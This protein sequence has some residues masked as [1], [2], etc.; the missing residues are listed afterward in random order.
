VAY[1]RQ[2]ILD[3]QYESRLDKAFRA[4]TPAPRPSNDP[5]RRA[6]LPLVNGEIPAWFVASTERQINRVADITKEMGLKAPVIVGAQ[7]GWRVIPALKA[8][9]ATAVVSLDWPAPN[10]VTGSVFRTGVGG[11]EGAGGRGGN[12]PTTPP[13]G[14]GRAGAGAGPATAENA[15]VRGNAAALIKAGV[16][17]V[18]A[19]FGG[20][21]GAVFRD[22]IR[23]TIE[24]G[25]SADDALRATTMA[26][27]ALL[28]ITAAV[29]TIDVGKLANLVVVTGN[30]LFASG[31]PIR[32]VFV[33]GRLY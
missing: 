22:R 12:A 13:T 30:D 17:V 10:S 18:L 20:E 9:G 4:G 7:E 14:G 15:E 25:M 31:T 27:A 6:L 3:A 1:V 26:P 11:G 21:S 23:S 33:E 2:A 29:G 5:F 16:P 8:S 28:G 19:S 32:H 24:A